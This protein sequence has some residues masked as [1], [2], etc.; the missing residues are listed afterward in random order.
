ML[1]TVITSAFTAR[2]IKCYCKK[3]KEYFIKNQ[4]DFCMAVRL[5]KD[6]G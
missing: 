3:K 2:K 4:W 6:E 5:L 1:L